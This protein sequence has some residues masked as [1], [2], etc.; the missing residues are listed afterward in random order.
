[1]ARR[2]VILPNW[3]VSEEMA[4]NREML[5]VNF[6]GLT[7]GEL[8][9]NTTSGITSLAT[10]DNTDTPVIFESSAMIDK[11]LEGFLDKVHQ[12]PNKDVLD[13]I[14]SGMVESW[15]NA[16]ANAVA[17]SKTY[18]DDQINFVLCG[19]TEAFDTLK[20]VEE[21]I[22]GHSGK[23]G[24]IL[25]D[26]NDLK[27]SAH[28][29][30]NK[31]LLDTYT[32]TEANL[33]DAVAKK[34]EHSNKTVL[35]G[36]TSEK[37]AQWDAAQANIIEEVR[38]NNSALTVN[39]KSVNI[40]LTYLEKAIEEVE[41]T[42]GPQG[43]PGSAA[44]IT[45]ATAAIGTNE[46]DTP[47]VTV[48]STGTDMARGFNFVFDNLKGKKGD[49]GAAAVFTAVTATVSNNSGTPKVTV[50]SAGTSTVG[51]E[52]K[53]SGLKGEQGPQGEKGADGTSIN[54]LGSFDSEDGLNDITNPKNGDAYIINGYL[55]VWNG[56]K[57]E[58]VGQ[59]KG[60]QGENGVTPVFSSATATITNTTG[61]PQVTITSAATGS[62]Y[63]LDFAFSGL[64]GV[65]GK[66]G[67]DGS[68]AYVMGATAK[69]DT[70]TGTPNVVVTSG[71]THSNITFD[72][73]FS[74][75]KGAD[76]KDGK[77]GT[78]VTI[79]GSVDSESD[80]DNISSPE[81]GDGYIIGE[82]LW[83][84]NGTEWKNVG[85][86][87]GPK[88]DTG[89]GIAK[90]E[91][92]GGNGAAGSTDTYT[93]TYT[94]NSAS[95][96]TVYNGANGVGQDGVTPE[97][98]SVKA[99]VANTTGT[100]QV[101][102]TSAST[103]SA[104][105]LNFAFSGLKGADGKNGNTPVFSSATATIT[106]T[107]GTPKV[108]ITSAA[109]G[110]VYSLDFDF[111]G[112]KGADG[113]NGNTP[114]F[115]A[116]TANV[117][118]AT[119]TPQV[120]VI[121]AKTADEKYSMEF[122]FQNMK[123]EKGD[124]GDDGTSVRILGTKDSNNELPSSGNTNGDG[125]IIG[126]NLWVWNGTEWED[127]G[128][129]KGPK[130]DTGV[131]IAKIERT[132]GNGAAGSTDT[133]TI[134]Y[135][136]YSTSTFT[137][138]NGANGIGKDGATPVFS[139]ATATITN[140]TGTPQVTI[141]SAATGS[142]YSLDFAFS[143]LKGADGKDGIG[144][145][146]ATPVF[147]SVKASVANTTGTPQVTVTSASTGSVYSLNFAFSGLK[148]E[149]GEPGGSGASGE[150]GYSYFSTIFDSLSSE[151]TAITKS[152][153]NNSG[154]VRTNDYIVSEEGEVFLVTSTTGTQF[155]LSY[156]SSFRGPQGEPGGSGA[157]G[158]RGYSYFSTISDSLTSASTAITK[159]SV[160]NSGDV[161]TN[162]YIVSTEG[163]VFI[164]T[165][166]T[167]LSFNLSYVS[168]FR[169]PQGAQGA[170]GSF[171]SSELDKYVQTG[172]TDYLNANAFGIIEY[173]DNT[174]GAN[175]IIS[176]MSASDKICLT[177]TNGIKLSGVTLS[178][179][180]YKELIIKAP[181]VVFTSAE[182]AYRTEYYVL[183][184]NG[185]NIGLKKFLSISPG[186]YNSIG[187]G[188]SS[189]FLDVKTG[190]TANSVAVGNHNHDG[191]YVTQEYFDDYDFGTTVSQS[192]GSSIYY[193]LG[194]ASKTANTVTKAYVSSTD[195]YMQGGE[196]YAASDETLKNFGEN[197]EVDF[198]KLAEIPKV[199]YTW[200]TDADNKQQIGTSAQKLREIYPELVS[201]SEDGKLAVSYEK[202]SVIALSAVDKLHKENEELKERL[203]KIEE[204]LGI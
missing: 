120:S 167:T 139:S 51:L 118:N 185:Y 128:P 8:V 147:S 190:T 30:N 9:V 76:G 134:T 50:V 43:V 189:V 91:R 23:T 72:F 116:V 6:S 172:N 148:G 37:V 161:R 187:S 96:F 10:L 107:T 32:Q 140:T 68:S 198:D 104:Y 58:N 135:T 67:Q 57:W 3:S 21:W 87:K 110:S 86:V 17:S 65:D 94:N 71:G 75:L 130:G 40:D 26:I 93:I 35:D 42:P 133:Y 63:S 84:W 164:V 146:G 80:L 126:E 88:G 182:D 157:S 200:K 97:F 16:E 136:D 162:D 155:K 121:T 119:G 74:G 159:S 177:G 117:N 188:Y 194:V 149:K 77:D 132:G 70:S 2:K 44:T 160:N 176:A 174:L 180:I 82:Y 166:S 41:L 103:G 62:V 53:F 90:I 47:T 143:G 183:G 92:T 81:N 138:Y 163:K 195:I 124:K 1:M 66:D 113:K 36:I 181:N 56:T 202:L 100:P 112:L 173:F 61:T 4:K 98:S 89:V 108:T 27:A 64:K 145:D 46:G 31:A 156:V 33:A 101:T 153:V 60:P 38:V 203:R 114:V 18:T 13:G 125:Y 78:S 175:K 12:H 69:V 99:S 141:T 15:N 115:T 144:Q 127:V 131:G 201:E 59:I 129:I 79:K 150:R 29:H 54:I 39:G 191:V 204:K 158:E 196:I 169:G 55:Y 106:N 22:N 20:E 73:A 109:T 7:M 24:D 171:D 52:F 48:N 137:V 5:E 123:G 197:I 193:L 19:A 122:S 11:R 45:G 151:S 14:T 111:S 152:Y 105:S 49:D 34:H 85:K 28:T 165:G 102:V 199:Y 179:T 170:T 168:S 186:E 83:V 25:K 154:S 192:T 142:V 184:V 95:T 178:P